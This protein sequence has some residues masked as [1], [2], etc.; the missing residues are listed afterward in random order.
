[1]T[2]DLALG[3]KGPKGPGTTLGMRQP[4]APLPLTFFSNTNSFSAAV[5]RL[6]S[7]SYLQPERGLGTTQLC[8]EPVTH[9]TQW[10][11]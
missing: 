9:N 7:S 4:P 2:T 10:H 1:M 3:Y 5:R 8:L 11:T 6:I